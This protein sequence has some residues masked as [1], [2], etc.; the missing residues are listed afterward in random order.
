MTPRPFASTISGLSLSSQ[1]LAIQNVALAWL[2]R[3]FELQAPSNTRLLSMEGLRGVAVI[4][5][6]LQ[7]YTVQAQLIGLSPG[8]AATFAMAFRAYGNQGVELFFVLSGYLIYGNLVRRAPPFGGFMARRFERIYPT[9]LAVFALALGAALVAPVSGK[10]SSDAWGKVFDIA[11]NLALLPGLFPFT[12]IV[13][14]AWSLSYEMFFYVATAALVLGTGLHT[15]PPRR[16][17]AVI[18]VLTLAFLATWSLDIPHFP[19]RM[20]PFF[21]GMLLAEGIGD[22][23]PS[24]LGWAAPL[25]SFFVYV[26]RI[27]PATAAD[28]LQVAAFFCLCAVC[29]RGRGRVSG[30]MCWTPLRWLGNMSYSFYLIHGFVV[31]AAML[32]L[33]MLLPGGMTGVIFWCAMP[34]LL[35]AALAVSTVLFTL[36][37]KPFSLQPATRPDRVRPGSGSG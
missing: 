34:V 22:G 24:W 3:T 4:L 2:R 13:V 28:L 6:F 25:A 17:I 35:G 31:R 15:A 29:F 32:L 9:F 37:E 11:V 23:V 12:P 20:L 5:V 36:V 27:V 26:T 18:V 33:A 1:E 14:V 16:R 8:P 30:W 7:H 19:H 21:A 10:L